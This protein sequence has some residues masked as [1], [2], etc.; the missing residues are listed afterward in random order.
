MAS[1]AKERITRLETNI[2][3][4]LKNEMPHIY[5]KLDGIEQKQQQQFVMLLIVAFLAGINVLNIL[6]KLI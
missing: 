6:I 4:I 5:K 1:D 2:D 3:M